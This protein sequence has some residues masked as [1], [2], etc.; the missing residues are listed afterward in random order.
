MV[1]A[2]VKCCQSSRFRESFHEMGR[3]LSVGFSGYMRSIGA[4]CRGGGGGGGG[5]TLAMVAFERGPMV[6][7]EVLLLF[8][9]DADDASSVPPDGGGYDHRPHGI[10]APNGRLNGAGI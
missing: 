1:R 9:L 5:S 7:V 3:F 10:V 2:S 8:V 6:G 4:C